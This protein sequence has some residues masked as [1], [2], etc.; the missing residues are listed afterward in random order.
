MDTLA[1]PATA[2]STYAEHDRN[3]D[4]RWWAAANYLTVAQIYLKSNPLARTALT[5][6]LVREV[7]ARAVMLSRA[8]S[9]RRTTGRPRGQVHRRSNAG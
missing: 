9:G 5:V 8:S 4:L 7:M 6:G 3:L 2:A 1:E